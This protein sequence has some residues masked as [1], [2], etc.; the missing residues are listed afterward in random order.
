MTKGVSCCGFSIHHSWNQAHDARVA[1]TLGW[2]VSAMMRYIPESTL[3]A[4]KLTICNMLSKVMVKTA[5]PPGMEAGFALPV[6][7]RD[8]RVVQLMDEHEGGGEP[9]ATAYSRVVRGPHIGLRNSTNQDHRTDSHTWNESLDRVRRSA[10]KL[11]SVIKK[12]DPPAA[13]TMS[14]AT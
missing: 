6:M 9:Q 3:N 14:P 1:S 11:K 12:P 5:V 4:A 2:W 10:T 13:S 8:V 7:S